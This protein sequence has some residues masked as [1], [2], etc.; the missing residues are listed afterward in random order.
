MS[1]TKVTDFFKII[2]GY[3]FQQDGIQMNKRKK[4]VDSNYTTNVKK[5]KFLNEEFKNEAMN[6]VDAERL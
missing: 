5:A 3:R 4:S 2:K 1:Q 6:Q